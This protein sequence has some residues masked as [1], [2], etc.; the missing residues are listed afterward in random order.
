MAA[1][2]DFSER[3]VP[4]WV[5]LHKRSIAKPPQGVGTGDGYCKGSGSS[6][7]TDARLERRITHDPR[8]RA[9]KPL[10]ST[11]YSAHGL[12]MI[13]QPDNGYVDQGTYPEYGSEV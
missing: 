3:V 2:D 4:V 9:F 5:K 10:T 7:V 6:G 13:G 12:M 11:L 8:Q 1:S